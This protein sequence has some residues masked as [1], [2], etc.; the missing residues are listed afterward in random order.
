MGEVRLGD[1][2]EATVE[3]TASELKVGKI[4]DDSTVNTGEDSSRLDEGNR[5]KEVPS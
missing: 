2:D 1:G 5:I 4:G 3:L